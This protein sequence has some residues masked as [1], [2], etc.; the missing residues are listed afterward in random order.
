MKSIVKVIVLTTV[1]FLAASLL[2]FPAIKKHHD[3]EN[4]MR[5]IV[6]NRIAV[7]AEKLL[8]N[9]SG[10]AVDIESYRREYDNVAVPDRVEYFGI[11][12]V[13]AQ[14]EVLDRD[15]FGSEFV[16]PIKGTDGTL[17]GFLKIT[18]MSGDVRFTMLTAGVIL[19]VSY[20]ASILIVILLYR[21]IY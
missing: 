2:I 13:A 11:S 21:L 10:F 15:A 4:G 17:K 8:E 6:M 12:E 3:N 18:Y 7:D 5:N 19:L 1:I 20:L 16:C 9:G 14:E